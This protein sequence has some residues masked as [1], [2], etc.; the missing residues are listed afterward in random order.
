MKS[1]LLLLR[2][3]PHGKNLLSP[4]AGFWLLCARILIGVMGLAE[5]LSW[6]RLGYLLGGESWVRWAAAVI[7]GLLIGLVVWVIDTSL[8]TLDRA[9]SE[10][11]QAL[12]ADPPPATTVNGRRVRDG[13]TLG[14]RVA[15]LFASL[16]VTAPYLA[17]IVLMNDIDQFNARET[18]AVIGAGR[19][20]MLAKH[21][22][23]IA[24]KEKEITAKRQEYEKETAGKGDSGRYGEG[25]AA[26]AK[27]RTVETLEAERASL[28]KG[29]EAALASF[30]RLAEN[31]QSNRERLAEL[32]QVNLPK[33]S[34]LQSR[35]ALDELRKTPENQQTELAI[36][37]FLAF[38]FAGLLLLKLFEPHSVRLYM[39][40][41]LQ[42]EYRRYVAGFF[43]K[44]LPGEEST[45]RHK[46]SAQR[47]LEFLQ[48]EWPKWRHKAGYQEAEADRKERE[49]RL[50]AGLERERQQKREDLNLHLAQEQQ[51]LQHEMETRA[52]RLEQQRKETGERISVKEKMAGILEDQLRSGREERDR[53][54]GILKTCMEDRA[55]ARVNN[56]NLAKTLKTV[57]ED[58]QEFNKIL[59]V[60]A[61]KKSGM[62]PQAAAEAGVAESEI[63]QRRDQLSRGW[64]KLSQEVDSIRQVY[65]D[66]VRGEKKAQERFDESDNHVKRLQAQISGIKGEILADL[67]ELARLD[68]T[69]TRAVGDTGR[70][71]DG[72]SPSTSPADQDHSET[73]S[74]S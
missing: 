45:S 31:P 21:D 22:A 59:N 70:P 67:S 11:A 23:L 7:T 37:A 39:S 46:M 19:D 63:R 64:L 17:Q 35:K 18:S 9:W 12:L 54:D 55:T 50:A 16:T 40:E 66:A 26:K 4:S 73:Q 61:E 51:R 29:K 72:P 2:L 36:K 15:L 65:D 24:A 53:Y 14:L 10:H 3:Q 74:V 28:I 1:V 49:D 42:S 30:N 48:K 52:R 60:L 69:A 6:S 71:P 62:D 13:F 57:E 44:F 27:L 34:L 68:A 58:I 38:I 56:E 5:A 8:V 25:A 41:I 43:D 32:Y 47:F 33:Q 20:A